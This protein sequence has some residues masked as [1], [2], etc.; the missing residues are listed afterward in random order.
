MESQGLAVNG[1]RKAWITEE[2]WEAIRKRKDLLIGKVDS[3]REQYQI[4]SAKVQRLCRRDYNKYINS[5][6]QDIEDHAQTMHTKDLFLKVKSIIREFK[7]KTWA[8]EDGD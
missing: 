8:I 2:T 6:C 1:A 4:L 3:G 7:P 5:I